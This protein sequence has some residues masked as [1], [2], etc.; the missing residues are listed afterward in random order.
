MFSFNRFI[1][2]LKFLPDQ[3]WEKMKPIGFALC[4]S[5]DPQARS[6]SVKEV[7]HGRS[8]WCLFLYWHGRHE[9]IWLNSLRV[10]S[11]TKVFVTRWPVG[12]QDEP[13]HYTDS[14]DTHVDQNSNSSNKRK[15][16]QIPSTLMSALLTRPPSLQCCTDHLCFNIELFF[17]AA[18]F[19]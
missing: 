18:S 1:T 2:K 6:R 12:Q 10:M 17:V 11:K 7:W 15:T 4:W 5:C 19:W 13:T 16:P 8:Q 3:M 14:Y 9:K